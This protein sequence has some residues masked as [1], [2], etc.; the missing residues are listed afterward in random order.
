M[1]TYLDASVILRRALDE[2][3]STIAWN[4]V[5]ETVTSRITQVECFRA[6]DRLRHQLTEDEVGLAR[7]REIVYRAFDS[8]HVI[9]LGASVLGQAGM[10]FPVAIKTLDAVHLASAMTYRD[11]TGTPVRIATHDRAL[12]R[13]SRSMGFEVVGAP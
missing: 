10:P 13:A 8:C 1:K 12:A 4:E 9:E 7:A 2:P 11:L 5:G 6:L 3:S